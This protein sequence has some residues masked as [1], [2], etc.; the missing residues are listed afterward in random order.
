MIEAINIQNFAII[1][2]M[3]LELDSGLTALTGETGAGKSIL[4]DAINLVAG[5]R[6]DS[7][8]VKT[9]T[10]KA[11]ISVSFNVVSNP[12][13]K[14]WLR[15]NDMTSD[16]ECIIRRTVTS[17]GRSR[18]FINGHNATLAQLK[19]LSESLL[20]IHGQHAHQSLQKSGI[21]RQQLDAYLGDSGLLKNVDCRYK[22]LKG[23]QKEYADINKNA[24][25]RQHRID[26]LTLYCSELNELNLQQ[27]EYPLLINNYNRLAHSG[28]LISLGNSLLT[29]LS[30]H[31]EFSVQ[32]QLSLCVQLIGEQTGI[33]SSLQSTSDLLNQSL[34][35]IEEVISDL[36]RHGDSIELDTEKL[37]G[38]NQRIASC[39]SLARKHR[40]D[41]EELPSLTTKFN[42]EFENLQ[43]AHVNQDKLIEAIC[44]AEK[45]YFKAAS[46]LSKRRLKTAA[47]LSKKITSA[48]QQLGM[49]GGHFEIEVSFS[50]SLEKARPHG[51]DSISYLVSANAGIPVKPLTRVA[52]GGELSRISLA[53]QV[54]MSEAST[55]PTLIFDEVDSGVGGGTAERVGSKLRLLGQNRQVLCVTHLAQVASQAHNHIRVSKQTENDNTRTLVEPLNDQ[56]RLDETARMLGGI[57]I[58]EQTRAHA[59]EM[60][61]KFG[62]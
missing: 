47:Q 59:S 23:L 16:D 35:Q 5:D 49:E 22:E 58:T 61:G 18:G 48:M 3:Q 44:A 52:S 40:V 9:G 43:S 7:H 12:I 34:I 4:L 21:Q 26:L 15:D 32:Q 46:Q 10:E 33:D 41:S 2:R 57:I 55:L 27:N 14:D 29:K 19:A 50:E 51:L 31:E 6:A 39:Q 45:E 28:E 60:I 8:Q 20:D 38:L 25:S 54:I 13:V 42:E 1:D 53:I 56:Q 37:D 62:T 17:Q 11:D 30:D 36:R 24:L